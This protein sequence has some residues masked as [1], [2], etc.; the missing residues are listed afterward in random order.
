MLGVREDADYDTINRAYKRLS[1]E[2]KRKGGKADPAQLEAIE[3]AHSALVTRLMYARMQS[4]STGPA[5]SSPKGLDEV[6]L[7]PWRT[8][9]LV[10]AP[11]WLALSLAAAVTAIA[12]SCGSASAGPQPV[13][14]V[15]FRR[16]G[17]KDGEGERGGGGERRT[18]C[19]RSAAAQ[20]AYPSCPPPPSSQLF[21][22][23]RDQ[24]VDVVPA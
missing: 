22:P 7:L 16:G 4:G 3:A 24:A 5:G 19:R 1:Y 12:W 8:R 15:F 21:V 11:K 17:K 10:W 23:Q 13:Q 2:E 20:T 18:T 14:F 6:P 9:L